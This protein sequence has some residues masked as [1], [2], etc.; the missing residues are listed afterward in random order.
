[1]E[2]LNFILTN[3]VYFS[4]YYGLNYVSFQNSYVGVLSPNVTVFGD[5]AFK[6]VIRLS[7]VIMAGS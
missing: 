7:K 6:E 1:M 4:W 5:W 2:L 3:R